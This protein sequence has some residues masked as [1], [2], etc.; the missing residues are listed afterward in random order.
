MQITAIKQQVKRPERYSVFVDSK[1]SF[2]LSESALLNSGLRLKQEIS[3]EELEGLKDTAKR[4]KAYNQSLGQ[5]VRRPRSEWEIREYLKR[6][7][8]DPEL[9]DA[10]VERLYD[11]KFLDDESFAQM[12][13]NSRRTLKSTSQRRLTM[14]L[15]QKR[16]AD[17]VVKRVLEH[18]ETDERQVIRELVTKKR[19]Q[20]RYQDPQKL[21]AYL[22]RQGFNYDDVKIVLRDPADGLTSL[23]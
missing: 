23:S 8:Y 15:R 11:A 4:D 13:V 6:K 16:V 7:E 2:S 19:K 18:D 21:M 9:I 20:T 17:D 10:V 14:E 1:Y 12:W 22:M 3:E 5:I